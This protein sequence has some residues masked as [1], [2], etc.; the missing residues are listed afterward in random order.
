MALGKQAATDVDWGVTTESGA[1]LVNHAATFA[2]AT[3]AQVFVM[4]QFGGSKAVVQF[5]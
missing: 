1:S 3:Q 2:L 5:D 4:Q